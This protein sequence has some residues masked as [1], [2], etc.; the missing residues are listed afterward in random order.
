MGEIGLELLQYVGSLFGEAP[1]PVGWPRP[2]ATS[3]PPLL[4]LFLIIFFSQTKQCHFGG[5]FL[6]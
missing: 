2:P 1:G 4:N 6:N 5:P 3:K